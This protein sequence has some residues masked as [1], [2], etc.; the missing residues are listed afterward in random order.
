ME[1]L[2]SLIEA[3]KIGGLIICG[4]VLWQ[5]SSLAQYNQSITKEIVKP[6]SIYNNEIHKE[7]VNTNEMLHMQKN[8]ENQRALIRKRII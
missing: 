4:I 1:L 5:I 3:Q 8:E 7:L 6:I 2:F